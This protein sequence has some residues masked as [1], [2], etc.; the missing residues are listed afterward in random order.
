MKE[1]LL[2]SSVLIL[3]LLA[4]R[5]V[6]RRRVSRRAQYALWLLV[7]VRLLVP[8]SL[9]GTPFSLLTAAEPVDQAVTARLENAAIYLQ[10]VAQGD[11]GLSEL[12]S[13]EDAPP[14]T[15]VRDGASD[16]VAA[17]DTPQ[18]V[19]GQTAF[20]AEET[21]GTITYYAR[22]LTVSQLLDIVWYA[23]MA[24]MAL[25][26]L[27]TNLRFWRKLRKARTP[28]TVEGCEY[29]VYLVGSG[30][31]S[32]CL[33]GLFR[34][35]IYLTPAAAATLERLRHVIAHESAH[36]RHLDPLWALLRG[37]CLTVYWFDPLVWLAAAVSRADGELAC[38]ESAL[39]AL[40]AAERVPYGQTLLSL[41]PVQA[42]PG[43]PLLSATTMTAGKR[44]LK[45]RIARIAE[46]RQTRSAALFAVLA[47]VAGVCAVT[48]TGAG[49]AGAS[50]PLTG[51]EL[52]W[53]NE[54]FFNQGDS[55][56]MPNQ[57]LTC[58][59]DSPEEIDL[60][61]L[62][63]NGTGEPEAMD[64]TE[65]Q[66]AAEAIGGD[67][68]TDL[69]K[70]SAASADQVLETYAGLTLSQTRETG[71][72]QFTYLERTDAY[73]H[74]H[75]DT[76]ALTVVFSA[77][78]RQGNI[79]RLYYDA[80]GSFLGDQLVDS[81][82]CVTLE[83]RGNGQYWFVSHQLCNMPAIPTAYPD[84]EAVLTLPVSGL[85]DY[86]PEAVQVTVHSGDLD[87][88]LDFYLCDQVMVEIYRSTDG[89]TYAAYAP[90][91]AL[92]AAAYDGD[93]NC[94]FT[95]PEEAENHISIG[96]FR[97]V[98]GYDGVVISYQD[99]LPGKNEVG[100]VSDYYIFDEGIF[101]DGAPILLARVYGTAAYIDLDGNGQTELCASSGSTAQVFFQK[102]GGLYEADLEV[103]L[104]AAWP[105]AEYLSFG[106]W[107]TAGR[108]LPLDAQ[109][110]VS[111]AESCQ[112]TAF[113]W[114]YFDGDSFL[115][116]RDERTYTDHVADD[117]DVP[118]E[119][120]ERMKAYVQGLYASA[121]EGRVLADGEFVSAPVEYDDWRIRSVTGPVY[122]EVADLRVEIWRL[123]YQLHTTTPENVLLAGGRYLTE[124]GWLSAGYPDCD[125]FYF[126][127]NEDG[128]RTYLFHRMENDCAPGTELFR[129]DLINALS[130]LGVLSLADL[131]GQTLLETLAVQ[132]AAFLERLVQR[133]LME[134]G[135]A[136]AS[137]AQA[138]AQEPDRFSS[139]V[140]YM[141]SYDRELSE[142]AET[143]WSVL[144]AAVDSWTASGGRVL[145]NSRL[146]L[147]L[148]IP[149]GWDSM[150]EVLSG[151]SGAPVPVFSLYERTAHNSSLGTGLVWSLTAFTA[152]AFYQNW[153][154]AD[155]SEVLG[156]SSYLIGSDD[157]YMYLLSTPTD[158]QFLED[159]LYSYVA[160]ET[161]KAQSQQVLEDFLVRNDI[162]P[163][164]LCPDAD[165]CYR[166]TGSVV[167]TPEKAPEET[168]SAPPAELPTESDIH[169]AL[170]SDYM[171]VNPAESTEDTLV[172]Q[173]EAHK[174]LA[175]ESSG[176]TC[177]FYLSVWRC[178]FTLQDGQYEMTSG[179]RIPTALT[180]TWTGGY[181]SLTE[182]WTPGDG[183][184]YEADLRTKFPEEAAEQELNT[185][186]LTAISQELLDQCWENAVRYFAETTGSVPQRRFSPSEEEFTGRDTG[187]SPDSMTYEERL[188][189][190]L[191]AEYEPGTSY[192]PLGDY[193]EGQG[194]LA[195][196]GQ[197]VG[198]PHTDQY[199]LSLRF[200][201]GT[202]AS[203]PLPMASSIAVALPDEMEFREGTFVYTVT[204]S[205][206]LLTN[207]GQTLIHLRGTYRYEV[208]LTSKTVSLTVL[209]S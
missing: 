89:N 164:P 179:D 183:A 115:V 24:I 191:T 63:Y 80:Y 159:D 117:I 181:W 37:V 119:V 39:A 207:E 178:T 136:I 6:F 147:T 203:L 122:E 79:I 87:E 19:P 15:V 90:A 72:D 92:L 126:Q 26:L 13:P 33:F 163:N 165:G 137:L 84:W 8:L 196:T 32:P 141:D 97:D 68:D 112:G 170:L 152:D 186:S 106:S 83:D 38:D 18:T 48:F 58:L 74:F 149:T 132:P 27:I 91:S 101:S 193:V 49:N 73:Y 120:L 40:G 104:E 168:V 29:P 161:L 113:R 23:G 144:C 21:D 88:E 200:A 133:S 36:A 131:P 145:T 189:W 78:E 65:R 62:F 70:F 194:C 11:P 123:D 31:S 135:R 34:P 60:F 204:F 5:R 127:M 103:L 86:E 138:A 202:L 59:Y 111:G 28:Y 10:P 1:I 187:G 121:E 61:Q 82:A 206:Q 171:R 150:A 169:S 125:Y 50:Q 175:Q 151:G 76:N 99:Q 47:L 182:Y 55:P 185:D 134:Q 190:I 116:Y 172:Y 20:A 25:W 162:A 130:E 9:P 148:E 167:T 160:Y 114:L 77:G 7:L 75:G 109:V 153:P 124:D 128:A 3:A 176:N 197:W 188:E 35:A 4:L 143:A 129:S 146:D 208:D 93:L 44:Q 110:P 22:S 201:D 71:L 30:L 166:Y 53:F 42:G 198:V 157:D 139:C 100:T 174:I 156:A 209:E 81:W 107:D 195:Y 95:F 41:I 67:P 85:T 102:N 69:I 2:T 177:T 54:D 16:D 14:V 57:F 17:G 56:C 158:V 96:G 46:N 180:F 12:E 192:L 105:E 142:A 184:A 43:D 140:S 94:F 51:E 173:T 154:D 52:A 199:G 66:E 98:L 118:Q 64:E 108:Y 155:G 205:D 45:D